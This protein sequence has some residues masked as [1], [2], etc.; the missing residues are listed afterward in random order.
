ML[1]NIQFYAI[2]EGIFMQQEIPL[3]ELEAAPMQ[4][5]TDLTPSL[6]VSVNDP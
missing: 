3:M 6:G 2:T 5:F 4:L 1:R